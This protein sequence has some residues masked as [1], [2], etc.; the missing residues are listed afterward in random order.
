MPNLRTEHI[1]GSQRRTDRW[2]KVRDRDD[3]GKVIHPGKNI[4]DEMCLALLFERTGEVR[5]YRKED[6]VPWEQPVDFERAQK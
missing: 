1:G 3:P 2:M 6:C 4:G 5:F